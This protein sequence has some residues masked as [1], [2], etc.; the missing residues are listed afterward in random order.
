[1]CVFLRRRK[2]EVKVMDKITMDLS[3]DTKWV[4]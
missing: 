3:P 1:M 4:R 2:K